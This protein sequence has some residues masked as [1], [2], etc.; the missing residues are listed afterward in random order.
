LRAAWAGIA[1]LQRREC[2]VNYVDAAKKQ[3][4][5]LLKGPVQGAAKKVVDMAPRRATERR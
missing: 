5:G 3:V 1:T 2:G 4:K